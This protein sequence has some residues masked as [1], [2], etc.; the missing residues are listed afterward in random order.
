MAWFPE[1]KFVRWVGETDDEFRDRL[2]GMADE[3]KKEEDERRFV[4]EPLRFSDYLGLKVKLQT[5]R[6][7]EKIIEVDRNIV[8]HQYRIEIPSDGYFNFGVCILFVADDF[9]QGQERSDYFYQTGR[10]KDHCIEGSFC[11]R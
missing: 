2:R 10:C 11:E 1:N 5:L 9:P 3:M 8:E 6:G 7:C 4:I